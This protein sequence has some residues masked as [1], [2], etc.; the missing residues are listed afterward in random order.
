MKTP[1]I[2]AVS[3]V[4]LAAPGFAQEPV[5]PAAYAPSQAVR[6]EFTLEQRT[7]EGGRLTPFYTNYR[8]D[9][10]F[11]GG[12]RVSCEFSTKQK[13][14]HKPGTTGTIGMTCPVAVT[15]GQAF[16]AYENRRP[17]GTGVV[18]PPLAGR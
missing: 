12:P 8:P 6:A 17:I 9:I 7:R 16:T 5:D 4:T 3:L 13:G 15:A 1:M 2:L 10:S 11:G 14:G 18:L